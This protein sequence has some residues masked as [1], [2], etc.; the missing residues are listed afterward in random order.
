MWGIADDYATLQE[1]S[2]KEVGESSRNGI[3]QLAK[4][5]KSFTTP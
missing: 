3:A 2:I 4:L 1:D 5:A